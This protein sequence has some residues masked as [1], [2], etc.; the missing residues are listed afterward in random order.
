MFSGIV[1][2]TIETRGKDREKRMKWPLG[3][4]VKEEGLLGESIDG[5]G[6][7]HHI[8]LKDRL[9]N[10]TGGGLGH[11]SSISSEFQIHWSFNKS[12]CLMGKKKSLDVGS[13]IFF[14]FLPHQ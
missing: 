13:Q 1:F 5:G 6:R 14:L 11:Y 7:A 10:S 12:V 4:V 3:E 2:C 8:T 9:K